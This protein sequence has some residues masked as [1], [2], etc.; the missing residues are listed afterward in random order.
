MTPSLEKRNLGAQAAGWTEVHVTAKGELRGFP[1]GV[2]VGKYDPESEFYQEVWN[3][4]TDVQAV[5][6]LIKVL[7]DSE[8][9]AFVRWIDIYVNETEARCE[10]PFTALE[11]GKLFRDSSCEQ[12]LDACL[13]AKG[14]L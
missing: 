13:K 4:D 10:R 1:E 3:Y 2:L 6:S 7:D 14:L 9:R 12:L 11:V 8:T 5:L